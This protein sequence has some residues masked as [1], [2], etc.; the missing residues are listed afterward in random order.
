MFSVYVNNKFQ[1]IRV[2]SNYNIQ[3]KF[4]K[5]TNIEE[6]IILKHWSYAKIL[7]KLIFFVKKKAEDEC[8]Y[9]IFLIPPFLRQCG[10]KMHK[11]RKISSIYIF[12][13]KELNEIFTKYVLI[14]SLKKWFWNH[15]IESDTRRGIHLRYILEQ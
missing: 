5:K 8:H 4:R 3:N 12:P 14:K 2:K 10:W 7:N 15:I 9:H 13:L 11:K 1:A 6:N